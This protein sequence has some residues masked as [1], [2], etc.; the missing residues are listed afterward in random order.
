MAKNSPERLPWVTT[1]PSLAGRG[2][3]T[4]CQQLNARNSAA[5]KNRVMDHARGMLP[6]LVTNVTAVS[7]LSF[8]SSWMTAMAGWFQLSAL[9]TKR[10]PSLRLKPLS[11][12]PKPDALKAMEFAAEIDGDF[13]SGSRR[14]RQREIDHADIAGGGRGGSLGLRRLREVAGQELPE[15]AGD[16]R[17]P[18]GGCL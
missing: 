6:E 5:T 8:G 9:K 15:W 1:G 14:L 11:L 13:L 7:V 2:S 16:V 4:L 3:M 17:R 12:L 18:P 10:S